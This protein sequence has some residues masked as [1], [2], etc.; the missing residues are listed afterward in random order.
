M[1]W[2]GYQGPP[3]FEFIPQVKTVYNILRDAQQAA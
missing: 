1:S 3:S 2:P